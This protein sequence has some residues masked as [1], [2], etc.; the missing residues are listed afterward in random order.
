MVIKK[1]VLLVLCFVSM[2]GI[3]C[4]GIKGIKATQLAKEYLRQK[5]TCE[6][7]Y[8][9]VRLSLEPGLYRVFFYPLD[10]PNLIIEVRIPLD[11]SVPE[12]RENE[13]GYFVQD[14][15]FPEL[16]SLD[17]KIFFSQKIQEV[18]NSMKTSVHISVDTSAIYSFEVPIELNEQM[19]PKDMEPYLKYNIHISINCL[20]SK[21]NK[22]EEAANIIRVF[23]MINDAGYKPDRILFWYRLNRMGTR[24]R[25]IVF[26]NWFEIL[27]IS[28]VVEIIDNVK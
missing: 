18:W 5:Y 21:I 13:Y 2:W 22:E 10:E 28:Q 27:T 17:T 26:K 15:Y 8:L 16:F 11:L 14:N 1:I 24:E 3:S 12:D 19:E 23:K 20:F 4:V 7:K 25:G 9:F 6:M